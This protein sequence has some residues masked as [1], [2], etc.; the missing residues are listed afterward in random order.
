LR[1]AD[2]IR[3]A[4]LLPAVRSAAARL[5]AGEPQACAALV[6][7]WVGAGEQYGRVG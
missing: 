1:V 6:A 3:D 2:L 5:Q 4:D 7:R